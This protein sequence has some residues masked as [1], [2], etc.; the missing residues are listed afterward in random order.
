[1]LARALVFAVVVLVTGACKPAETEAPVH[2]IRIATGFPSG[3]FFPLGNALATIYNETVPSV[4]ASAEPTAGAIFNV[5][6]IQEGSMDLGFSLADI[7]YTAHTR[8]IALDPRPHTRL[9]G[10]AAVYVSV[11]HLIVR[12]DGPFHSVADLRGARIGYGS[13]SP[14]EVV[15]AELLPATTLELLTAGGELDPSDVQGVAMSFGDALNAFASGELEVGLVRAGYPLTTLRDVARDIDFRLLEIQPAAAVQIR[16]KYPFYK[17]AQIPGGTY[18]AQPEAVSTVGLD[19]VLLCRE[20]LDED[21][22]YRLTKALFDSLPRLAQMHEVALQV[23]PDLAPAT[24]IPLH[25]GAAR[26]YRE[27]ELFR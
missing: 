5:N 8:G 4:Y 27:R 24:P 23:D 17:P 13:S 10:I 19:N 11:L 25:P 15:P 6:A 20:D 7:A 1:M 18:N 16:A 22:V 3:V 9:R 26:Y 2:R 14:D 21:L 12:G